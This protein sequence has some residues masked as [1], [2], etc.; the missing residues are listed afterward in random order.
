MKCRVCS[1]RPWTRYLDS[2]RVCDRCYDEIAATVAD[3]VGDALLDA[4]ADF[5]LTP[6]DIWE[7]FAYEIDLYETLRLEEKMDA[8]KKRIKAHL[9]E[10]GAITP[11]EALKLYGTMRLAAR[12]SDLRAEGME[13][14]T[15]YETSDNGA[16]Y[17]KYTVKRGA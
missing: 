15:E 4:A 7:V 3:Y 2:A 12:I 9:E 16:R 1:E 8:Q 11:L 14:N 10:F 13:I 5:N 6:R 17:A